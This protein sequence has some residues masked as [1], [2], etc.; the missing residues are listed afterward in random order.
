MRNIIKKGLILLL[1]NLVMQTPAMCQIT[2]DSIETKET[3]LIFTEHEYLS[4][5]NPLLKQ[6]IKSLEDTKV[7]KEDSILAIS[8]FSSSF[9]SNIL[10]FSLTNSSGSMK[11]VD[12][13][14]DTSWIIPF[15]L[16]L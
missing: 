7:D 6:Q 1:F 9:N 4:I 2:L 16:F 10:L 13:V 5:E 12:P 8:F 15:T 11:V 3:V 14:E